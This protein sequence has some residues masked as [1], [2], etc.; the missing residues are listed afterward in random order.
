MPR[1]VYFSQA[2]KS[3]QN[4]YE[5][6]I[7]ESL[8]IYGQDVYYIPR[9]LVNRDNVL[10]EDPAS[11]FD[12]AYLLEMYIENTD[13]FEGAGDLY[14]KFGLEIR[15]E[16]SFVVS[17]RRWETRVGIYDDNVIDPRPQEGDLLFLPMTNSFFEI[18]YVEDDNPFFQLSN[19]PVYR[20]SCSLF[21]YNDE[22]FDTGI[23]EIDDKTGQSAYQQRMDVTISGGNHFE[24]G[25]N[26]EQLL[27]FNTDAVTVAVT[28][29][30]GAFY[31]NTAQQLALTLPIGST[32]TFD[33][34]DASN[35]GH[36]FKLSTTANGTHASG[37]EYT[38]GVAI[39]G[40]PGSAGAKTVITVSATT[41]VLYYYCPN[42]SN[43]GGTAKLTPQYVS[44]VKVFGEVIQR[45]KSSDTQS[46]I[47]VGH[48]GASGT[49]EWKDFTVGGTITGLTSTYTGTIAKI[50]SDLTDPTDN[51]WA[52]DGG[53]QNIDFE[54]DADGFIDF[55]ESN[56]FGDPSETY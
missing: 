22:D 2:V 38:T 1:N 26:V 50:Y 51:A 49:S 32:V 47:F 6:L 53:A 25:E 44:P 45:I 16:A 4:L 7:I 43:M 12:D 33:Q 9:T 29:A 28:A 17:R 5:D 3:E 10:N 18:S 13:G 56:P 42:H 21:E 23:A 14:S 37:S 27:S 41:P 55:S 20:M 24:V 15:D 8:Q 35:T 31:L 48:I 11:T 52:A 36:P 39:T 34:S 30:G 19:L 46:S 40:T 54:L